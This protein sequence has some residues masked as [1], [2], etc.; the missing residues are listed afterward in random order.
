MPLT[1]AVPSVNT[2]VGNQRLTVTQVTFDSSYLTGG[3]LITPADVGLNAIHA[4]ISFASSG[5][6]VTYDATA[7]SLIVYDH[8]LGVEVVST[9]DL[10]LITADLIAFGS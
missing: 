6:N 1:V 2:V 8:I 7:G 5:Y 3:E 4:L 9:T 10:A